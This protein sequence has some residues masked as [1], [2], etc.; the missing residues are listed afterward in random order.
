MADNA[1][2]TYKITVSVER[3]DSPGASMK[4]VFAE[5]PSDKAEAVD[6]QYASLIANFRLFVL[7]ERVADQAEPDPNAV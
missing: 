6:Y 4:G 5:I 7:G 2:P 1:K 3:S